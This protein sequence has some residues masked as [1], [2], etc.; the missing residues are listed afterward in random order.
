MLALNWESLPAIVGI[1]ILLL[2]AV[3]QVLARRV[4]NALTL[5][6]IESGWFYAIYVDAT[7]RFRLPGPEP[8]ASLAGAFLALLTML[9]I[10]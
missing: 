2:A 4:P 3:S 7:H 5:S 1:V 8:Q 9:P 10:Y 6:G